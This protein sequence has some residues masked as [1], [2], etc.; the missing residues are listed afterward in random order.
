MHS[1]IQGLL[2]RKFENR[3]T[4]EYDKKS[5]VDASTFEA[6]ADGE[7]SDHEDTVDDGRTV[8]TTKMVVFEADHEYGKQFVIEAIKQIRSV[9]KSHAK[10]TRECCRQVPPA[11]LA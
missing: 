11:L 1:K 9:C 8:Y 6:A 7:G 4:G 5:N 10:A 3:I 2:I